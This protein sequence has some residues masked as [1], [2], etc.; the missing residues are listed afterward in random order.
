[1]TVVHWNPTR[2][3]AL[4]HGDM[5]R[6]LGRMVP[7]LAETAANAW[8]PAFDISEEGDQFVVRADLPGLSQDDVVVELQDRRL[9]VSGERRQERREE[10]A[11]FIRMERGYGS[12]TRTLTL[13]KGVDAEAIEAAFEHG[14]L[15]LRIPK[16]VAAEPRRIAI[17][18]MRPSE[19]ETGEDAAE[20]SQEPKRSLKERVLAKA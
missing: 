20:T 6:L 4:L 14:V 8:S 1:M 11:S 13:P 18:G 16:P 15:E 17:G 12:F 9:T 19:I 2:E 7:E 3:L 10:H 5:H